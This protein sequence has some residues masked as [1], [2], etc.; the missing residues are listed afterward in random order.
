MSAGEA[1][2]RFL[3]QLILRNTC[4]SHHESTHPDS[5]RQEAAQRGLRVK[6]SVVDLVESNEVEEARR[7]VR[8]QENEQHEFEGLR[9]TR[10]DDGESSETEQPRATKSTFNRSPMAPALSSHC[11][12]TANEQPVKLRPPQL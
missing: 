6:V 11:A 2:P 7:Q 1:K 3:V 12:T 5:P 4:P 9:A 10:N 8:D